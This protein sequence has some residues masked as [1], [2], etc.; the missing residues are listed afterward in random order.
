MRHPKWPTYACLLF[1]NSKIVIKK[2][3][4]SII[5]LLK[6]QNKNFQKFTCFYKGW[7]Y[8]FLSFRRPDFPSTH[9]RIHVCMLHLQLLFYRF[10]I[11]LEE[12]C[13][14]WPWHCAW[15]NQ[16]TCT[17]LMSRLL[18]WIQNSVCMQPRSS[19]GME[20]LKSSFLD[21]LHLHFLWQINICWVCK[22]ILRTFVLNIFIPCQMIIYIESILKLF[23]SSEGY[24]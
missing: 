10:R 20:V 2:K 21:A 13:R 6:K 23:K 24:I 9:N 22:A 5:T 8:Y 15:V 18:T 7:K 19:N 4:L 14:E 12:S 3:W 11:C 16:Q 17:W 1:K